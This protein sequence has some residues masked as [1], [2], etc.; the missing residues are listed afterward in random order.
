MRTQ[1]EDLEVGSTASQESVGDHIPSPTNDAGPGSKKGIPRPELDKEK[2]EAEKRAS[3]LSMSLGEIGLLDRCDHDVETGAVN[4]TTSPAPAEAGN[5]LGN[6]SL[7]QANRASME[8]EPLQQ[9]TLQTALASA[10]ATTYEEPINQMVDDDELE[11]AE[12][13]QKKEMKILPIDGIISLGR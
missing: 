8:T 2:E 7:S 1:G 13:R 4:E 10:T 12:P 6:R 3:T 11:L 9:A 5:S